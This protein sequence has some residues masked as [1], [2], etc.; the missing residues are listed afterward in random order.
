[1]TVEPAPQKAPGWVSASRSG[2]VVS[3]VMLSLGEV[4]ALIGMASL[5]LEFSLG[6]TL[7]LGTFYLWLFHR[8]SVVWSISA[9]GAAVNAQV[10]VSAA[11]MAGTFLAL[12][13]LFRAGARSAGGGG[14]L[15]RGLNGARVAP[16]YAA[17]SLAAVALLSGDGETAR[18]VLFPGIVQVLVFAAVAGFAGGVMTTRE[19]LPEGRQRRVLAVV[20]GAW[21]MLAYGI[22][23]SFIALML[24]AGL[25]PAYS[26]VYLAGFRAVRQSG[27]AAAL[28][29]NAMLL[30]NESVWAMSASMGACNGIYG[31][32]NVDVLCYSHF[33]TG[34]STP[35][36]Q[37]VPVPTTVPRIPLALLVFI[38]VPP[39]AV[40]LGATTG[41]RFART[42]SHR[43]AALIGATSGLVFS[44]LMGLAALFAGVGLRYVGSGP[45][46]GQAVFIGPDVL[47]SA[48]VTAAWGVAGGALGAMASR[49]FRR[50]GEGLVV[51]HAGDDEDPADQPDPADDD[52]R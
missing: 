27:G 26:R 11:F 2:A 5:H 1:M 20:M 45:L 14:L 24:L 49:R 33:P 28:V 10:Y 35:T 50:G 19:T 3:V 36:D 6:E 37:A 18:V 52:A 41:E 22:A 13:L 4:L 30:P 44:P 12:W 32:V 25:K 34:L 40:L 51:D 23:A 29:N 21:G 39:A 43:E 46:Q 17:L 38:A 7:R 31:S 15:S 9:E 16:A 47:M 42:R 8:G 48:L